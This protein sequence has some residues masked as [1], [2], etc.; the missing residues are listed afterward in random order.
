MYKLLNSFVCQLLKIK[1]ELI[2]YLS[3]VKKR[4]LKQ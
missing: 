4:S 1:S 3:I 2:L